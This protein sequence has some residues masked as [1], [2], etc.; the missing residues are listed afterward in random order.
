MRFGL[1]ADDAIDH[2]QVQVGDQVGADRAPL[3]GAGGR[4]RQRHAAHQARLAL[5][6]PGHAQVEQGAGRRL[7]GGAVAVPALCL[8]GPDLPAVSGS[9]RRPHHHQPQPL[10]DSGERGVAGRARRWTTAQTTLGPANLRFERPV[11]ARRGGRTR[12]ST[13]SPSARGSAERRDDA[14]VVGL[15]RPP[16]PAP[17]GGRAR[18]LD[19]GPAGAGQAREARASRVVPRRVALAPGLRPVRRRLGGRAHRRGPRSVAGLLRRPPAGRPRGRRP[20]RC[21]P[22]G[23]AAT[24]P[25]TAWPTFAAEPTRIDDRDVADG[26]FSAAQERRR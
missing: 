12:R 3:R 16:H 24:S 21:G 7:P 18:R 26:G 6:R 20:G 4:C 10:T 8:R 23:T 1:V 17:D 11:D 5:R 22:G 25:G 9:L 2:V 13:S 14:P 19:R 15:R